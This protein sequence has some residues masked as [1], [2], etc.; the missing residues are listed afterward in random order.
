MSARS[1]W[2]EYVDSRLPESSRWHS[3]SVDLVQTNDCLGDSLIAELREAT[4][5]ADV[6]T[7]LSPWSENL[8]WRIYMYEKERRLLV[9]L[10]DT[11]RVVQLFQRAV[12]TCLSLLDIRD[13]HLG[14][15]WCRRLQQER[16]RR[17]EIYEALLAD[18][19]RFAVEMGGE[20][21]QLEVL[22]LMKHDVM[23]FG[24]VLTP[25][26]LDVISATFETV[27]RHSGVV[28]GV[29]PAWLTNTKKECGWLEKTSVKKGGEEKCLREA[30]IWAELH[31][32]Y[33]SKFYGACHVGKVFHLHEWNDSVINE[34]LTWRLLLGCALGL[35]YIHERGLVHQRLREYTLEKPRFGSKWLLN[36]LGL[37]RLRQTSVGSGDS[38]G[39][40]AQIPTSSGDG[41]EPSV[42]S[43]VLSFGLAIF[44]IL[45]YARSCYTSDAA[46]S[47]QPKPHGQLPRARPDA[48]KIEEW[49]LLVGMCH[50]DPAVRTTMIE[51]VQQMRALAK[52]EENHEAS[53]ND[54]SDA[55]PELVQN[56]MAYVYPRA[57]QTIEELLGGAGDM[58]QEV[59]E[60]ALLN[61]PV[62][63]RLVDVFQQLVAAP[64]PLSA[65]LVGAFSD[66]VWRFYNQLNPQ[67][68]GSFSKTTALCAS[69]TIANRNYGLHH[70]MNRLILS[71]NV[72]Q[73]NASIHQWQ[74]TWEHARKQQLV[75]LQ[76]CL[77]NPSILL[78][79]LDS[80]NERAEALALLQYEA[81]YIY[82]HVSYS[83]S[84]SGMES[85]VVATGEL[86]MLGGEV[87]PSWFIPL[88][89]VEIT[90]RIADGSL[91]S[92]YEGRWLGADVVMKQALSN[93]NEKE[94][95]DQF[96]QQVEL[97]LTLNHRN[98]IQIYGACHEGQ[99]F[100]VCERTQHGTLVSFGEGKERKMV[101][102]C[103]WQAALGL[104]HL[105]ECGIV[106]GDL[107]ASKILCDEGPYEHP[108]VKLADFGL[109]SV[110]ADHV[111][112]ANSE[113]TLGSFRWKAPECLNGASP[114][115]ASDTYSFGMCIIE[116][117][118]GEFPWGNSIPEEAVK[119]QVMQEKQLPARPTTFSDAEW[120]LVGR[121]CC[122]DPE[123]RISI[124]AVAPV[125]YSFC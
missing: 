86:A 113:A 50:S 123:K 13:P 84:A 53:T 70:E 64:D 112:A 37:V 62:H 32:P 61:Q 87:L 91:D 76:T 89:Q 35:E 46:M 3:S 22:T 34:T 83:S 122:F 48:L 67:V 24:D 100:F 21:Q 30:A 59:Q 96:R 103:L 11:G 19:T 52:D 108:S 99:P 78:D 74:P 82:S 85:A 29:T 73:R 97:W 72:L 45:A 101:L 79:Q 14:T 65:D 124:G 20:A 104:E 117:L 110:F 40:E 47:S 39:S 54:T 98:L 119:F 25:R 2:K 16:E 68:S 115:F 80:E 1:I 88:Y 41:I 105:H 71:S 63:D 42:S 75:S 125:L 95:R 93:Q 102:Y 38:Q 6:D 114:T 120:E 118:S 31:H 7:L 69:R 27:S 116:A 107:T 23:K 94:K 43:D 56:V 18:E 60:L 49:E 12:E 106:H 81:H 17:V 33:V 109:L 90:K 15:S 44:E 66:V 121:M 8:M 5:A 4:R 77:E 9:K 111:K 55:P 36:G 51:V 26:E 92:A 10:A 58:C 28:V 57:G